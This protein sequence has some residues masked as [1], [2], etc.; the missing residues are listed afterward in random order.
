MNLMLVGFQE[1]LNKLHTSICH[2]C[3][4][5]TPTHIFNLCLAIVVCYKMDVQHNQN[6]K[7]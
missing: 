5:K 4:I 6:L 2:N 3:H 7:N 1:H